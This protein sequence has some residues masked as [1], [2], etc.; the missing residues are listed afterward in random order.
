MLKKRRLLPSDAFLRQGR[1]T[2]PLIS[3]AV[4]CLIVMIMQKNYT[5][6]KTVGFYCKTALIVIKQFMLFW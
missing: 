4:G 3:D 2:S 1:D 6:L 5:C